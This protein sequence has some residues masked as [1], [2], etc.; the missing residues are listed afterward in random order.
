[1][2][3][4]K[5]LIFICF[6]FCFYCCFEVNAMEKF[7]YGK[8][9]LK[10]NFYYEIKDIKS[11]ETYI[12]DMFLDLNEPNENVIEFGS[13]VNSSFLRKYFLDAKNYLD[14]TEYLKSIFQKYVE[15]IVF[16]NELGIFNKFGA[17]EVLELEKI[18]KIFKILKG[19]LR[20][21]LFYGNNYKEKKLV[22]LKEGVLE[23]CF[24]EDYV[25]KIKNMCDVNCKDFDC[26][27]DEVKFLY[28]LMKARDFV[29]FYNTYSHKF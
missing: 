10:N 17:K 29:V 9:F 28:C 8:P 12:T 21:V 26:K 13:V 19:N 20:L 24:N 11:G 18:N 16:E 22:I 2:K 4:N 1:M 14:E 23:N 7:K 5:I 27:D 15:K 25:K 6:V 3:K